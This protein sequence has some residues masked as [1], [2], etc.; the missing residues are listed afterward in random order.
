[1][2][3]FDPFKPLN[4]EDFKPSDLPT[5]NK[6]D[7][8]NPKDV[9]VDNSVD[10]KDDEDGED[11]DTSLDDFESEL[12]DQFSPDVPS[13]DESLSLPEPTSIQTPIA[14]E[15]QIKWTVIPTDNNELKSQHVNGFTLRARPL[16]AKKDEKIKYITQLYKG[17]KILEKGVIWI[18]STKDPITFLQNVA[19]RILNR[20]GLTSNEIEEPKSEF[21][22]EEP[23]E[24]D[25]PKEEEKGDLGNEMDQVLGSI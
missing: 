23:I 15:K 11:A 21:T 8:I 3:D 18:D 2:S 17:N 25:L 14:P 4:S 9:G 22:N 16:S 10:L 7:K 20:M 12:N 19:D 1:M 5:G 6:E 24:S 13:G